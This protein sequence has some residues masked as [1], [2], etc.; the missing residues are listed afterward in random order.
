MLPGPLAPLARQG[1]AGASGSRAAASLPCSHRLGH[2]N[3]CPSGALARCLG[4]STLACAARSCRPRVRAAAPGLQPLPRGS[5]NA[6]RGSLG[7]ALLLSIKW[8][9]VCRQQLIRPFACD[10]L[11]SLCQLRRRRAGSKRPAPR[12]Q[13]APQQ[14]PE[15][16]SQGGPDGRSGQRLPPA[17]RAGKRRAARGRNPSVPPLLAVRTGQILGPAG[18]RR[19]ALAVPCLGLTPLPRGSKWPTPGSA[20]P[21]RTGTALVQ[22]ELMFWRGVPYISEREGCCSPSDPIPGSG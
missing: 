7:R 6:P 15:P 21:A 10:R 9:L 8:F 16:A 14:P 20:A 18:E 4:L 1:P 3:R 19:R 17:G 5:G 2:P 11:G 13:P 12:T 22:K